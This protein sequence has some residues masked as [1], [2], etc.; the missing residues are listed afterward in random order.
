MNKNTK[1]QTTKITQRNFDFDEFMD[2]LTIWMMRNNT[3]HVPYDY[4]DTRY[5]T[6]YPL[7][8]VMRQLTITPT[9]D[10]TKIV[11]TKKQQQV[12]NNLGVSLNQNNSFYAPEFLW[13]IKKFAETHKTTH[14]KPKYIE[15]FT[16]YPLGKKFQMVKNGFLIKQ[17]AIPKT[18]PHIDVDDSVYAELISLG[19]LS[20]YTK[21]GI[22]TAKSITF[23]YDQFVSHW[24]AYCAKQLKVH[25]PD[26]YS[27]HRT[28]ITEDGYKLGEFTYLL[29]LSKRKIEN[30]EMPYYKAYT[31]TQEQWQ[32]LAKLNFFEGQ[33]QKRKSDKKFDEFCDRL[34]QYKKEFG[35]TLVPDTYVCED[36][37]A[38][39][40]RVTYY[41]K[42]KNK[43]LKNNT[44]FPK[45][46]E[47]KLNEI[48]FAWN[49]HDAIMEDFFEHYKQ[50]KKTHN[51]KTFVSNSYVCEDGYR[52]G[53]H[54]T[55]IRLS[56]HKL[57]LGK[58]AQVALTDQ[59]IKTLNSLGFPW[60]ISKISD[61]RFKTEEKAN[62]KYFF[63]KLVEYKDEFND[64][65]VPFGYRCDDGYALGQKVVYFRQRKNKTF[66]GANKIL[67]DTQNRALEKL[68]FAWEEKTDTS[69]KQPTL[70]H[71][72]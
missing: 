43:S 2:C 49:H 29:R 34:A 71:K 47:K 23:N 58:P 26:P 9:K 60:E 21:Q 24:V 48:G 14:I 45:D 68:G 44:P 64:L 57:D 66:E 70:K 19:F 7:G 69:K 8:H 37:Y 46:R 4:V 59:N 10:D 13:Q 25:A 17:K 6:H 1:N 28:Y 5:D 56:K 54:A 20:A 40:T 39:G 36:G 27:P 22:K 55:K 35:N 72:K 16:N 38:L 11:L 32:K 52:L 61:K 51:N 50:Y 53:M 30:G 67:V 33:T 18:T 31:L 62:F 65:Q 42:C 12:L 41:R 63:D 3:T 15:R